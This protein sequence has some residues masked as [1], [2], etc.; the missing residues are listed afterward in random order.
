MADNK[1]KALD[2]EEFKFF[3]SYALKPI[4]KA[5]EMAAKAAE[6]AAK[7]S[8]ARKIN[9]TPFDGSADVTTANWGT[10][11][12]V[13]VSDST[14]ANTGTATSVNG[15]GDVTLKLPAKIK[16]EL[17]GNAKTATRATKATQD[18]NGNVIADTYLNKSKVLTNKEQVEANT[19]AS[20]VCGA[21]AAKEIIDSFSPKDLKVTFYSSAHTG[22]I[23]AKKYGRLYNVYG[24]CQCNATTSDIDLFKIEGLEADL[25]SGISIKCPMTTQEAYILK[26]EG[27]LTINQKGIAKCQY[28]STTGFLFFNVTFII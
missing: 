26:S 5:A 16:A 7:L 2:L 1:K 10:A 3:L 22:V 11:R 4:K 18:G 14:G 8:T 12:N 27:V 21:T 17:D 15:S 25:N 13:K 20:N 28:A 19:D 23:T 24:F 6:S 9:G